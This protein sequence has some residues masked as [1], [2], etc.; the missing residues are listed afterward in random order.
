MDQ[1][2]LWVS[3]EISLGHVINDYKCISPHS[4]YL[5]HTFYIVEGW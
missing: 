4:Y 1:V 2:T 5:L 3:Y